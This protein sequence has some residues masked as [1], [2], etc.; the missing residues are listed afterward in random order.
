MLFF[1]VPCDLEDQ[2]CSKCFI[3]P[4]FGRSIIYSTYICTDKWCSSLHCLMLQSLRTMGLSRCVNKYTL[5]FPNQIAQV[6]LDCVTKVHPPSSRLAPAVHPHV[7][8][9]KAT[10]EDIV[11]VSITHVVYC[12]TYILVELVWHVFGLHWGSSVKT[13]ADL[14]AGS[15]LEKFSALNKRAVRTYIYI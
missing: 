1:P 10:G 11:T 8:V 15:Q 5:C 3:T 2:D 14:K 4:S 12:Q 9:I 13:L 7:Y 6:K